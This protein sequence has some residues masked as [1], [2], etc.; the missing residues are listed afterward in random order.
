MEWKKLTCGKVADW[1]VELPSSFSGDREV[2]FSCPTKNFHLPTLLQFLRE[3]YGVAYNDDHVKEI[4][5]QKKDRVK[6]IYVKVPLLES[7]NLKL[8]TEDYSREDWQFIRACR[9]TEFKTLEEEL[10]KDVV[11]KS[12]DSSPA[13]LGNSGNL[14]LEYQELMKFARLLKFSTG[15]LDKKT[16]EAHRKFLEKGLAEKLGFPKDTLIKW[17]QSVVGAESD[18]RY[19]L[20]TWLL[21]KPHTIG[22]GK[23]F[24]APSADM[25]PN[26]LR[27]TF[28]PYKALG[29][30]AREIVG[31]MFEEHRALTEKTTPSHGAEID[32]LWQEKMGKL[33]ASTRSEWNAL[34]Q[35]QI[36]EEIAQFNEFV[37][38]NR[39]KQEKQEEIE[40]RAQELFKRVF[41]NLGWYSSEKLVGKTL[42]DIAKVMGPETP[43]DLILDIL[44]QVIAVGI[45]VYIGKTLI[46][47]RR[48][49]RAK[50]M[51]ALL[52]DL[53]LSSKSKKIILLQAKGFSR[54]AAFAATR[55]ATQRRQW[56]ASLPRKSRKAAARAAKMAEKWS[57]NLLRKYPKGFRRA[58]HTL[59]KEFFDDFAKVFGKD[60]VKKVMEDWLIPLPK[61]FHQKLV[62]H[63][64]G[65]GAWNAE[66]AK[67]FQ[68]PA[69]EITQ[70]NVFKHLQKLIKKFPE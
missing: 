12:A 22:E 18:G 15:K 10:L 50:R 7:K 21:V 60:K 65:G 4:M 44:L 51:A 1:E 27:E 66:W 19:G 53:K 2:A 13:N 69:K 67:F 47:A 8:I 48:L 39:D 61:K 62:H 23:H 29:S 32:P 20:E 57:D 33:A 9:T 52:D 41:D 37:K 70:E 31:L 64:R 59:P 45:T 68:R 35:K 56:I 24:F 14:L 26:K 16:F 43:E 5:K 30:K 42:T 54:E 36:K 55:Y 17:I 11:I 3:V 40:R 28:I 63:G 49:A 38:K 25:P 58:H 34:L 46:Q 6:R